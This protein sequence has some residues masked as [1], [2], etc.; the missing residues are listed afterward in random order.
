MSLLKMIRERLAAWYEGE[1]VP[2]DPASPFVIF[3]G[4][5][6]SLSARTLRILIDFLRAHWKWYIPVVVAILGSA[7]TDGAKQCGRFGAGS[8][9]SR[10]AMHCW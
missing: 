7:T 5:R 2:D 3:P 4:N 9:V 1:H 10:S 6:P 8:Q